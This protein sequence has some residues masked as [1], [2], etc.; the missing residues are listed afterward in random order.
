ITYLP[1]GL[2]GPTEN[3]KILYEKPQATS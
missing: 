1:L 3:L 2:Y